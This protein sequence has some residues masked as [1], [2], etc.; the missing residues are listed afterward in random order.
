MSKTK[1]TKRKTT[2]AQE[3]RYI[4]M[5]RIKAHPN[6]HMVLDNPKKDI[7]VAD[8]N[9]AAELLHI[10][11]PTMNER[12]KYKALR[13]AGFTGKIAVKVVNYMARELDSTGE[14]NKLPERIFMSLPAAKEYMMTKSTVANNVFKKSIP[15]KIKTKM[16]SDDSAPQGITMTRHALLQ[17]NMD[18]GEWDN[19]GFGTPPNEVDLN[20]LMPDPAQL[21]MNEVPFPYSEQ[22]TVVDATNIEDM[23]LLN[24][25]NDALREVSGNVPKGKVTIVVDAGDGFAF[26][27]THDSGS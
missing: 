1:T 6:L 24:I 12:K 8:M 15:A 25:V 27:M 7:C 22:A 4:L 3:L 23:G 13:S 17:S 5:S 14:L 18:D 21:D 20:E 9:I 19:F 16:V 26:S 10:P 11:Y 2:L